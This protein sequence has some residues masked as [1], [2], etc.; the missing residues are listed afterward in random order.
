[1]YKVRGSSFKILSNKTDKVLGI[2]TQRLY[3]NFA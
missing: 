3:K 2:G 1:M